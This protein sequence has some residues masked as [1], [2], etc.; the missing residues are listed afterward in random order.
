MVCGG[1]RARFPVV[2]INRTGG[3]LLVTVPV[4]FHLSQFPEPPEADVLTQSATE[5]Y[6]SGA[7]E[8]PGSCFAG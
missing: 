8:G 7:K 6:F 1:A 5:L 4:T 3:E 2:F